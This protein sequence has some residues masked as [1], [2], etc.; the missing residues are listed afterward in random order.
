VG[1]Y[2]PLQAR[3]R[4][5]RWVAKGV[6]AGIKVAA[7]ELARTNGKP[8]KKVGPVRIETVKSQSKRRGEGFK[9]LRHNTVPY[10]RVNK[11][12]QTI[13]LNAGTIIP[14]T[15][16]RIVFGGYSRI[17]STTNKTAVDRF[18]AK[19]VSKVFPMGT[20]RG[21]VVAY[22]KKN[23]SVTNPAIRGTVGG[24]QVRLGTSRGA[25]P[26]II[27]RRGKHKTS[28]AKSQTGVAKYDNQMRKIAGQRSAKIKKP[29]PQRRNAARRKR[30]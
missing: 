2:N 13:G 10:V 27:V 11:R 15:K 17:E 8:I 3:D 23:F 7:K 14:G 12:S 20:N 9:G 4:H 19:G 6:N 29:R 24:A 30:K 18:V 21:K 1:H 28:Q 26:T 25:G 22:A 16:K 5:G